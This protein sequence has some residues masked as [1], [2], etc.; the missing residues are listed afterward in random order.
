MPA[1]CAR[2]SAR[3][4][5]VTILD[6]SR[7]ESRPRWARRSKRSSPSRQLHHDERLVAVDPVVEDLDHVRAAELRR[8]RCL[9]TEPLAGRLLL[10]EL[11]VDE[12]DRDVRG[13]AR[14]APRP[15]PTPAIPAR[16]GGSADSA[17]SEL[18]P[19]QWPSGLDRVRRGPSVCRGPL[20]FFRNLP[21]VPL[22]RRPF[23]GRFGSRRARPLRT[24][25]SPGAAALLF[26][27]SL[28]QLAP[29]LVRQLRVNVVPLEVRVVK[30][31]PR[32]LEDQG[33]QVVAGSRSL[34]SLSAS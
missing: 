3:A 17:G 21:N 26:H 30:K 24:S 7:S 28:H 14:G 1:A 34:A 18:G 13:A 29:L 31:Q 33:A 11:G 27:G 6:V 16:P 22:E 25:R 32:D 10:G 5:W 12:L 19:P 15:R 8:S 23:A 2:L 9:A 20:G 4:T